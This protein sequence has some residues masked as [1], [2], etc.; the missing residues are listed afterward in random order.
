MLVL[1][2]KS[3]QQI[4]LGDG[5]SVTVLRVQGDNVRL[6]IQA[7]SDMLVLREELSIAPTTGIASEDA[8][9]SKCA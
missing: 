4:K 1:S 2:R 9:S 6:G 8:L 7:P 5:I 3:G